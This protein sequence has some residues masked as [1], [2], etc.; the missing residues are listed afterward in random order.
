MVT[1]LDGIH[2]EEK[3]RGWSLSTILLH[4]RAMLERRLLRISHV[5]KE[6]LGLDS[7]IY[8]PWAFITPDNSM[9][10]HTAHTIPAIHQ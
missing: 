2:T 7:L 9:L 5:S 3:N 4:Y 8:W 10:I 1:D 6:R